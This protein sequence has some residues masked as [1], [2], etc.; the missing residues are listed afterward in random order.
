M[1]IVEVPA[2]KEEGGREACDQGVEGEGEEKRAEGVPL[3]YTLLGGDDGGAA[4]EG[5]VLTVREG[6]PA[7]KGGGEVGDCP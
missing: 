7:G 5:R 1:A 3:L 6:S 4:V 2:I